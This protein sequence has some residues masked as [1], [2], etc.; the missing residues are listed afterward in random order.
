[1]NAPLTE[2]YTFLANL[3]KK[4]VLQVLILVEKIFL[5]KEN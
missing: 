2:N 1:M 5:L 4:L 3:Q